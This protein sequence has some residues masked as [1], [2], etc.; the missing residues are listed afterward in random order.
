MFSEDVVKQFKRHPLDRK[1]SYLYWRVIWNVLSL[2]ILKSIDFLLLSYNKWRI[3][4]KTQANLSK[5]R[6]QLS[7]Q[8]VILG[9][10]HEDNLKR[11]MW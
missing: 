7:Q 10:K 2:Q 1:D 6:R 3:Y 5:G 11:Y 4:L 8:S 9:H